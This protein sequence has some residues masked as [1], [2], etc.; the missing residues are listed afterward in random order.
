MP[1]KAARRQGNARQIQ[2]MTKRR[3]AVERR[4]QMP[5]GA[6][7]HP[8]G[9]AVGIDRMIGQPPQHRLA[10]RQQRQHG[11]VKS[12][13][14]QHPQ[15]ERRHERERRHVLVRSGQQPQPPMRRGAMKAQRPRR[16][17]DKLWQNFNHATRL[18]APRCRLTLTGLGA[19]AAVRLRIARPSPSP[20]T[21]YCS[22]SH[23]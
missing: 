9:D 10:V 6:R 3:H 20:N 12:H 1:V 8:H 2:Q 22:A 18:R 16:G 19:L 4:H 17:L 14:V 23:G 11:S 5:P 7:L 13:I 21:K 15:L